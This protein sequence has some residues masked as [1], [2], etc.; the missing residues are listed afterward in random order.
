MHVCQVKNKSPLWESKRNYCKG[1]GMVN[2]VS[3]SMTLDQDLILKDATLSKY[4]S[5]LCQ[6]LQS[7]LWLPHQIGSQGLVLPSLSR[8]SNF[9]VERSS[10]WKT[11]IKPRVLI[12]Q[13]SFRFL[14]AS[15][16]PKAV[17][18]EATVTRKI[19]VYPNN[20]QEMF[21]YLSLHRRAYNLA[22][23]HFKTVPYKD[24]ANLTQLRRVIKEVVKEEFKNRSY[25][26]E[27]AGEA[28]C[29]AFKTKS[30]VIRK[31]SG[32]Q[33][34]DFKFKSIKEVRQRFICQRLNKKMMSKFHVTEP[35][36]D[37]SFGKT[38]TIC[39]ES[40]RWF[41]CS[42]KTITLRRGA[43]NQGP[44]VVAIDPGVRTFATAY[45]GLSV[46]K[47]GDNFYG[48][49]I[50]PLLLQADALISKR[51]LF[52]NASKEKGTQA[53]QDMMRHY[54]KRINKLRNR[55]TDL[56]SDLHRRVAFDL[57]SS[58]DVILLPK[59]KT[60]DMS[61]KQ[62]RK[63]HTKTVRSMLGLAHYSFQQHVGWMCNKY[64]KTLIPVNEAWT[65]KTQS[66][67]GVVNE[68]LGGAR[69]I[70]NSIIVDRDSNGARGILLRAL[71]VASTDIRCVSCE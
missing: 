67:D 65:S 66:W 54:A 8:S 45:D 57:V 56:I 46:K 69:K 21:D 20:K 60:Q 38:T 29:L 15:A 43:D 12:P 36:D 30:A 31:R 32:K 1:L 13:P 11:E 62:G 2:V 51:T 63:I 3:M 44:S 24:Q 9:T 48:S 59:F 58:Y 53:F 19:Q 5:P 17:S 37:V 70:G 16:T 10:F 39:F 35:I 25:Q 42:L 4:W 27:I 14:P 50:F 34:C 28:V 61:K 6:E 47:Y 18:V 41:V 52:G 49:V 7:K 33:K 22:I 71:S 55:I 26:A 40:G 64:G 68:G 23:E